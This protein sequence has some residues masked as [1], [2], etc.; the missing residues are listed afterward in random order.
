MRVNPTMPQIN[1]AMS[2]DRSA[3]PRPDIGTGALRNRLREIPHA[4]GVY[5]FYDKDGRVIYVGKAINLRRRVFQYFSSSRKSMESRI[6]QLVFNTADV[7]WMVEPSEL[8]ALLLEDRLIKEHWPLYNTRQKKFLR[9]KYLGLTDEDFPRLRVLGLDERGSEPVVFGPFPDIFFVSDL[10][11]IIHRV[12]PIRN[13]REAVPPS[14]CRN[15]RLVNC[16]APCKQAITRE[17]YRAIV[18]RVVDF[19]RGNTS[20]VIQRLKVEIKRSSAS[21]EFERAAELRDQIAFCKRFEERQ[22]FYDRFRTRNLFITERGNSD[23]RYMFRHGSLLMGS[24]GPLTE[25]ELLEKGARGGP[26]DAEDRREPDWII[27]D[28]A[29]VVYSWLRGRRTHKEFRF[30]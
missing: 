30:V 28:R 12:Y 1:Q 3:F 24:R 6:Q 2:S 27:L 14:R 23:H 20:E 29:N 7:K 8:H 19:L 22:R 16:S 4:T 15:S 11:E 18:N 26:D 10:L 25:E 13:C 5:L 21:L 9:N 17:E